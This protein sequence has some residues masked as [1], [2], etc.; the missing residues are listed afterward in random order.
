MKTLNG[1]NPLVQGGKPILGCD[2]WEHSYYIDY[3]NRRPDYHQ[4]VRRS[5]GQL[6]L[7]GRNVP[8]GRE[9]TI[10][11]S[12]AYRC[13]VAGDAVSSD[14]AILFSS[15]FTMETVRRSGWP[16]DSGPESLI[17]CAKRLTR[18]SRWCR[19]VALS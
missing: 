11:C 5:P 9:I 6:G 15:Q 18:Q 7:R 1:E 12:P 2:V 13:V 14:D 19:L 10:N 4:G 17:L 16:T 8:G 3:R